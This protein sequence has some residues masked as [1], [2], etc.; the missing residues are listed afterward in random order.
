MTRRRIL[1]WGVHTYTALGLLLAAGAVIL[2]VQGGEGDLR[3]AL[4]LLLVAGVVDC[5]DGW[6]A[7]RVGVTEVLPHVDGRRLDDIIDFHTYVSIPLL[8]LWR[9]GIPEGAGVWLLLAPL[10]ASGYGFAQVEAKTRDGF[11][12]GFPSYWNVVAFYLFFLAPPS[13]LS[14]VIL[15][16]FAVLVFVPSPYLHPSK[17][18]PWPALTMTLGSVWALLVLGILA[19]VARPEGVWVWVSLAFPVYYLAV[20]WFGIRRRS[21]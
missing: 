14:G 4:L 18:G 12:R 3:R 5:T 10:L 2:I 6:L 21:G 20:S 19:G 15:A 17:G 9:A 11:F 7:R 1:A 16:G 8:L 13:W